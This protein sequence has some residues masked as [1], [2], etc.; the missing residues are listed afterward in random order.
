LLHIVN[1][2]LDISK[3]EA[4]RLDMESIPFSLHEVFRVCQTIIAPKAEEK[5]IALYCYAEP[6]VGK[7]LLGDPTRLRQVLLNL[8][9]NAVKFTNNGMVKLMA[10]IECTGEEGDD[11]LTVQFMVKDSG[12]G[13]SEEQAKKIFEPFVQADSSMT[14]RF[15]G[16][17]L[18]LPITKN[19]VEIMGGE[20]EL[21]TAIGIG[22]KFSFRIN[23]KT[24]D[25]Y[26]EIPAE[27]ILLNQAEKP[28]F[29]GEIL[30]CEDNA[31]NQQVIVEHLERVG[32]SVVLAGNGKE[33]VAYV[34]ER[35][36]NNDKPFDL[37]FMDI[38]MPAM[39][40]LEAARELTKM[41]N[42][43]P[44][45]AL[46]ANVMVNHKEAYLEHGMPDF[47]AKPFTTNELWLCL[48]KYLDPIRK[49]AEEADTIK[50]AETKRRKKLLKGFVND[51]V[52]TFAEVEAAINAGDYKTAH[53]L[54][55]TLKG[56]AA[57]IDRQPLREAA[58]AVER[59]LAARA[60]FEGYEEEC[61]QEQLDTLRAELAY[62]IDELIPLTNVKNDSAGKVV[63][64]PESAV[65]IDS[66]QAAY[67]FDRLEQLLKS[68][69]S[70]ALK[71]V[72]ELHEIEG[73]ESLI[74]QIEDYDFLQ[75][76]KTLAK[77]KETIL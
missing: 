29:N 8:L 43:T 38:H 75:A 1:D 55:H 40:G 23:F 66:G 27:D 50:E 5:G 74:K 58:F 56:L 46:T 30:V 65:V 36:K 44:V 28:I 7:K 51:H 47:I 63:K 4:G 57:M 37:I 76:Q 54:T 62:V 32:L 6:S 45:V 71:L 70:K 14:R 59:G 39:D 11:E 61:T 60:G 18:G 67:V 25:V 72:D 33:G 19:I 26:S 16:T 15:G 9:S 48:L 42:T 12:I 73:T 53:R 21:E 24:V 41:G 20:L 52:N 17:G 49:E 22:S 64:K 3:I 31:I 35:I 69:N 77:L 10:A 68:G 13:M 2:I 34:A